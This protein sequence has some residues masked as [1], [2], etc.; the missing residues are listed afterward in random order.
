VEW[1]QVSYQVKNVVFTGWPQTR[2][3]KFPEFS[4]LFQTHNYTFPEVIATKK[5]GD[6]AAFSAIFGHLFTAHAQKWPF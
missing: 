4:R 6:L 2:R 1:L 5:F 3:K